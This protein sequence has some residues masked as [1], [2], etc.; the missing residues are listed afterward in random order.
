MTHEPD[1]RVSFRSVE[2]EEIGLPGSMT[3]KPA[4]RSNRNPNKQRSATVQPA[5]A[6]WLRWESIRGV[7][8]YAAAFAA[9]CLLPFLGE[10]FHIDDPL[11][12]WAAKQIGQHPLNPYGFSVVWYS[13]SMS[14]SEVMKNPPL[15][16]YFLAVVA[17]FTGWSENAM[18]LA[19]LLPAMSAIF[20]TYG[21]AREMTRFPLLAACVTLASPGYMVSATSV[22]CDVPMLA[23]WLAAVIAWRKGIKEHRWWWLAASGV[24]IAICALTKYFGVCLIPLLLL[25]SVWEKRRIGSW[26]FF[27]LIP[28]VALF[29]YQIWT[30]SLYGEGLLS[31]LGE[32]VQYAHDEHPLSAV[33]SL[34]TALS[35]VGGCILPA[36]AFLPS[37]WSR[38]TMILAICLATTVFGAGALG[39]IGL[40]QEFPGQNRILLAVQFSIFI[41]SGGSVLVLA[42]SDFWSHR[43]ADSALLAAWVGGTFVFTAFLN[44]TVNARSILPMIPAAGLLIARRLEKGRVPS[45]IGRTVAPL[46]ACLVIS[47]WVTAGDAELANSM[48]TAAR[49][50][51]KRGS[52]MSRRVLFSG[53]WGF[54]YYME[55]LDGIAIESSKTQ[56]TAL[57]ILVR[58]ENNTNQ[59]STDSPAFD[60]LLLKMRTGVSV[61]RAEK[62]AG[63][64]SSKW[65]ILPYAFGPAPDERYDFYR[66]DR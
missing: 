53:H 45:S 33:A 44:W 48:R 19:M 13:N 29:G 40:G 9:L 32:Y 22:M 5:S 37:L 16:S 15:A 27:M 2:I 24:L 1:W 4:A 42:I 55:S 61:M 66:F 60:S 46:L 20:L 49:E 11:F 62:G 23:L 26:V 34:L 50:V 47:I 36:L 14:M 31:G 3:A 59:V 7:G 30:E 10:A 21:L 6:G 41:L 28:V 39:W 63:F 25:Y 54:Q 12:L 43:D 51:H 52:E 38:R 58:P 35:F 56:P 65:G 57:D 17:H 18:H 8:W 64:Y